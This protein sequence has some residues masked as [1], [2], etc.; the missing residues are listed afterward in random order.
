MQEAPAGADVLV[1]ASA[2]LVEVCTL[3][4]ASEA[5]KLSLGFAFKDAASS[6]FIC[7]L[8]FRFNCTLLAAAA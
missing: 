1:L 4:G 8:F 5:P 6:F 7:S 2:A 3:A